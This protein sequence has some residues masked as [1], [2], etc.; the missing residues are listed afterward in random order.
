MNG[1]LC[2]TCRNRP[3]TFLC[4]CNEAFICGECIAHHITSLPNIEH[5][6]SPL[7]YAD[8]ATS[9]R[10]E[11]LKQQHTHLAREVLTRELRRLEEFSH[12]ALANLREAKARWIEELENAV[13][14]VESRLSG[15]IARLERELK[16]C[17]DSQVAVSS[18]AGLSE[19]LKQITTEEE[20]LLRL[21]AEVK[22]LQLEQLITQTLL[23][24]ADYAHAN[25][26]SPL[27]Y[28]FFGGSNL[29]AIFDA[30]TESCLQSVTAS[31]KFFHNACWS[32]EPSGLVFLTGGSLTGKSRNEALEF[33]PANG[34]VRELQPMQV[35]RR[36]HAS[37]CTAFTSLVFGG[38]MD[39]ERLS[40]CERYNREKDV[41]TSIGNMVERRAYLG[42]CQWKG[43]IYVG[44]GSEVS[45]LEVLSQD[46]EEFSL[47]ALTQVC[48]QDNCSLLGVSDG[49]LIFHGSYHGEVSRYR[50]PEVVVREKEV[51]Y[52]NS[53]SNCAPV[54]EGD[55][56]FLLRSDSVF[57]Y[58]L[59]TGT[60][61]YVMHLAKAS[62]RKEY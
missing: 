50:S 9:A 2:G 20:Q 32:V 21:T 36:S 49:V 7:T 55:K 59:S 8:L 39:D 31:C 56:V 22:P 10:P 5:R 60:S 29:V 14:G 53:W 43:Q 45:S 4:F 24:E 40:R 46:T 57:C 44:G 12:T 51:C 3:A 33:N 27:L 37:I 1:N 34:K 48:I 47:V 52:G 28:K 54:C 16:H 35:A 11:P 18:D 61:A 58:H 6:L 42:C 15:Q 19:R 25:Q 13:L 26:V 38:I 23:F 30:K 41:W 62:K 17:L